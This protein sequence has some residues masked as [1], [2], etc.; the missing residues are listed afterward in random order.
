MNDNKQAMRP[1][2]LYSWLDDNR[3][4]SGARAFFRKTVRLLAIS[5]REF[6]HNNLPLRASAL[7]YTVLLSLVPLLAMS[8]AVVKGLGGGNQLRELAYSYLAT[9]EDNKAPSSIPYLVP[10][11]QVVS[12]A[13][14]ATLTG[15]LHE[16]VDKLF[17]YV[18]KTSF[19]TLGTFGILGIL[20]S[21]VLVLSTIETAMNTI[22]KV[23][24]GRSVMRKIADYL[25]LLFLLPIS[26][27][28][29]FAASAFLTSQALAARMELVI[30]APWVQ[31]LL[32]K[33]LPI[34][35][36]TF[37]FYLLYIFFPNT[38]VKRLPAFTGAL[39]AATLWF[40]MQY[41]YVNLQ[42]GVAKYNAIYGSFATLPLFLVWVWFGWLFIL[43]GAQLAYSFQSNHSYRFLSGNDTPALDLALAFD[44]MAQVHKAFAEGKPVTGD[45]LTEDLE[46]Y[47]APAVNRIVGL[48]RS[49][50]LLHRSTTD[51]R[52]LPGS[53][54]WDKGE[55][56]QLIFGNSPQRSPGST[57]SNKSVAA[58]IGA[59]QEEQD[60]ITE[61]VPVPD[62]AHGQPE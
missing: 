11:P 17:D 6:S 51:G 19:A 60:Q 44:I 24:S 16:A 12:P 50:A 30:P 41:V 52:L 18:D 45:S 39:L 33:P 62:P 13:T 43:I 1:A 5:L 37:T 22:W 53:E 48:L 49:A 3:A 55:L 10:E 8:T 59:V 56:V 20:L 2:A 21:V 35:V 4:S 42:V 7:T 32:L 36:F 31:Q 26:I 54:H 61:T 57:L 47:H 29:A 40:G 46:S 25:T 9:L 58:A 23:K 28:V 34:L 14:T 38:K 15:H 27:N